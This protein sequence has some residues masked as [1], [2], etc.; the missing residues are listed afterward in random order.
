M[1]LRIPDAEHLEFRGTAARHTS[2]VP[3]RAPDGAR[4]PPRRDGT[5]EPAVTQGQLIS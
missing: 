2:A 4:L 1:P 5:R 3:P